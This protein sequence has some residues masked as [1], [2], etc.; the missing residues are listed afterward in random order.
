[1]MKSDQADKIVKEPFNSLKNRYQNNL[2]PIKQAVTVA[3][4]CKEIKNQRSP[5][6]NTN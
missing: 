3:S 4:N 2:E 6:N 5:K 1:M